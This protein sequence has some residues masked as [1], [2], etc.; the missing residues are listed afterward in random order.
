MKKLTILQ[1]SALTGTILIVIIGAVVYNQKFIQ[2]STQEQATSLKQLLQATTP[3]IC[4]FNSTQSDAQSSG[5]VFVANGMLRGD[6]VST[7]NNQTVNSH[8]IVKDNTSYVWTDQLQEGVKVSMHQLDNK[9]PEDQPINLDEKMKYDCQTWTQEEKVFALP[10]GIE[11]QDFS[12]ILQSLNKTKTNTQSSGITDACN[13]CEQ[14]P[15][16]ARQ[17]CRKALGCQ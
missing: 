9:N 8:L 6:F 15:E 13:S 11:F 3:R 7:I 12:T 5:T 10:E 14:V 2:H 16:N 17:Q 4:T 1:L